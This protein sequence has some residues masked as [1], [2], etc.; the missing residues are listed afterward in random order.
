MDRRQAHC[1]KRRRRHAEMR[2]AAVI[3]QENESS[4]EGPDDS[5]KAQKGQRAW[6]SRRPLRLQ[7]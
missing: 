7:V 5:S 3:R 2:K 4:V 6:K 1:N